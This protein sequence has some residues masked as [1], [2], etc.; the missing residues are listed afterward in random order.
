MFFEFG[1]VAGVPLPHQTIPSETGV[2]F[3]DENRTELEK[4][5]LMFRFQGD[6]SEIHHIT[7]VILRKRAKEYTAKNRVCI[8]NGGPSRT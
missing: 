4:V 7:V 6:D 5:G 3:S 1:P 8:F 2:F